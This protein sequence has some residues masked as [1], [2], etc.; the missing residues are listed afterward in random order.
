M[1]SPGPITELL[2]KIAYEFAQIQP[3]LP[4]YA[5]LLVS[6][7]FPIYAGAHASLSRPSSA[8]KP[9]KRKK[10]AA[11]EDEGKNSDEEEDEEVKMEGL[12]HSDA[13]VFPLLAGCTLAGLYFLIKW[14]Q[15]ADLLNKILNWYFALFGVFSVGKLIADAMDVA[16]GFMFPRQYVHDGTVWHVKGNE[17]RTVAPTGKGLEERVRP[18]PLPGF[19]SKLPLST[20]TTNML[21]TLREL[22]RHKWTIKAYIHRILALRANVGLHGLTGFC[23]GLAAVL[24]FNFVDKPWYL[25]NLMGFGFAYGALQI[26]SPTTFDTGSLI[27]AALFLYD[28]YFVFFTPMM[29][30]VAKSLDVPIKLVFPRPAAP[31]APPGASSQAMLGLGDVV[32]PGIMIGLAL[33]FDLYLFYLRKQTETAPSSSSAEAASPDPED[34]EKKE[35]VQKAKYVPLT[36]HTA[37]SF[38]THSL[39]GR[40]LVPGLSTSFPKPY[41]TASII[42]YVVGMLATLGVMQVFNHAQPALLYLVPSVLISLWGTAF[43]RGEIKEMWNFS[44]AVE[45]EAAAAGEDKKKQGQISFFSAEKQERQAKR[46]EKAVGRLVERDE[47]EKVDE[48][49]QRDEVKHGDVKSSEESPKRK[50]TYP[51]RSREL[52]SFSISAP[53]ALSIPKDTKPASA[54]ETVTSATKTQP[55]RPE[56]SSGDE[57]ADSLDSNPRSRPRRRCSKKGEPA[58]KRQRTA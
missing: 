51:D 16:H 35:L 39:S 30:T 21:W 8:A 48:H 28:I 50:G 14:L 12:S 53:F 45:D 3:L 41:F 20:G 4:T 17:R 46:L 19:L 36:N 40:A 43:A 24:Y 5:H 22:P 31:D 58:E 29:V 11:D 54:A 6:A 33:R 1:A 27:L 56:S 42:G 10:S 55:S 57:V 49:G 26:M 25:I 18:S 15:N 23:L 52:V 34:A 38:W 37:E 9:V 47:G 44:E 2:G 7:L 13:L 32:L